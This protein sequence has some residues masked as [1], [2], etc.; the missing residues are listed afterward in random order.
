[1]Q[2]EVKVPEEIS[3]TV[4]LLISK[5]GISGVPQYLRC[6]PELGALIN[7]CFPI[8]DAKVKAEGGQRVLGWQIW[9]TS[10][11]VEAEFHAVWV[12]PTGE[13]LDITPKPLPFSEILFISDP[14]AVYEG[15]QV[16]NVRINI[17]GNSL[18]DDFIAVHDAVFRIENRGARA[19]QYQ[20][21][22][23]GEEAK[24][25]RTLNA[26]KP[27]LEMMALQGGTRKSPCPCGSGKKYKV[28]H[29]KKISRLI[30]D[31]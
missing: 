22:L 11:L 19:L 20:L 14:K 27:L 25:H 7:E 21:S 13:L 3:E 30:N 8:V 6:K 24:A 4:R 29:G 2:I 16:N 26:A 5:L 15:K 17:T 31:F 1:M 23:S 28:C 18:V 10:L 9:Q 12:S